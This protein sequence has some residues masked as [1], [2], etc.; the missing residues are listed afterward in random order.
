M[1]FDGKKTDRLNY[2]SV[3]SAGLLKANGYIGDKNI[4]PV[5]LIDPRFNSL[6]LLGNTLMSFFQSTQLLQPD[7]DAPE[8]VTSIR[9][10]GEELLDEVLCHV[11]QADLVESDGV[12]TIW[13]APLRNYR[14]KRIELSY[15]DKLI[16]VHTV[17]KTI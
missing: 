2:N 5:S 1:A 10:V 12:I 13:I 15:P 16:Q 4:I 11:I 6:G 9:L 7:L 8:K 3:D 14:P 17:F